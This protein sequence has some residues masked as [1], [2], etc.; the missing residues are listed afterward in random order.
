M[1]EIKPKLSI[2]VTA[3]NDNYGGFLE[4]R[5]RTF[6]KVIATEVLECKV[7]T[8]L[9]FVEYNPP[10]G[11]ELF[12]RSLKL[13]TNEYFHVRYVIVPRSF[14]LQ[15]ST[16]TK[17]PLLEYI[18][19]NIGI[20][21]ALGEYILVGNPDIIV[22]KEIMSFIADGKIDKDHFYRVDRCD[23][24]VN[25]FNYNLT[26]EEI[27][28]KARQN[29][30]LIWVNGGARYHSWKAWFHRFI[31]GR[32]KKSLMLCPLLN[33]WHDLKQDRNQI[34]VQ[35]AGDFLVAHRDW[36][37]KA[38]G[39]D[40]TPLSSYLDG[41]ILYVFQCLGAKQYVL[42]YPIF[43][44]D[45]EIG[46]GGRPEIAFKKFSDDTKKMLETGIPYRNQEP[47]WGYPNRKF[48]EI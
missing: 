29:V 47:N 17:I 44:I 6:V 2:V 7:Q 28:K 48:D 9:V 30:S 25:D 21:R 31:H 26:N 8:E 42:P 36:F 12:A 41:Y 24:T 39:Y 10:E 20:R 22:P 33:K 15:F 37:W 46:K 35:A 23:T 14:H 4:N 43:H 27:I 38:S 19:K 45:H 13:P 3:R 34:H 16:H 32:N 11:K 1:N 40:E 18:A 5:I